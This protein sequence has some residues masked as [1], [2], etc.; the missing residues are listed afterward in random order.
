MHPQKDELEGRKAYPERRVRVSE[1]ISPAD[2]A[3]S[4]ELKSEKLG[5]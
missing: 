1:L 3:K 2:G 5:L 4:Q